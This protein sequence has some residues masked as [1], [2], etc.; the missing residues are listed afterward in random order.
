MV[1]VGKP[2]TCLFCGQMPLWEGARQVE[3]SDGA[4]AWLCG[5]CAGM[6]V[7]G[8][9]PVAVAFYQRPERQWVVGP[10]RH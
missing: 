6:A 7:M 3:L 4:V 10:T 2:R 1:A 9:L 5:F 8:M